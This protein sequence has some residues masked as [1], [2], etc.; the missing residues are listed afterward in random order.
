MATKTHP[1]MISRTNNNES[2]V[3]ETSDHH[4]GREGMRTIKF[5]N[6]SIYN[7]EIKNGNIGDGNG[8]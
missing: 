1:G 6:G 4:Q 2:R 3:I 7:G 8:V 5:E